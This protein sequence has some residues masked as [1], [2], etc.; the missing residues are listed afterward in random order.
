[1]K[2][3]ATTGIFTPVVVSPEVDGTHVVRVVSTSPTDWYV[4]PTLQLKSGE[5]YTLSPLAEASGI[6][7]LPFIIYELLLNSKRQGYVIYSTWPK[8]N[9][10][11]GLAFISPTWWNSTKVTEIPE[12]DLLQVFKSKDLIIFNSLN[13]VSYLCTGEICP[14]IQG[15][16][17]I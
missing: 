3:V 14:E 8:S 4:L 13:R 2:T 7:G 12:G 10:N 9:T 15:S 16:L 5:T 17:R 11:F 1:M 6:S